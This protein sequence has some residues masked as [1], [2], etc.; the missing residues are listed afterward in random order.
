ML[1]ILTFIVALFC[2]H[3]TY[4]QENLR[5][6][7][8]DEVNKILT[9]AKEKN[10]I[11]YAAASYTKGMQY[12]NEA[13]DYFNRGKSLEDIREKI[14]N[15]QAYLAKSIDVCKI[16]EATFS[17]TT[18]A[19]KDAERAGAPKY[20]IKL[21]NNAEEKFKDAAGKLEEG[22][23]EKSKEKGKEAEST[24]RSAELEAI[25]TNYLSPARELLKN[26]D[27]MEIQDNSPI[28]LSKAKDLVNQTE[29]LLKQNRYDTDEARQL[30][31]EAKYEA[32]HAIYL[33][34]TIEKMKNEEKS[35]EDVLLSSE[36]HLNRVAAELNLSLRF[37][38]G[39]EVPILEII[40]SIKERDAKIIKNADA[41][42]KADE[43]I[44]QKEAE[45]DNLKQQVNLMMAR[46]GSLSEA[47]KKLQNEGKELQRKLELKHEQEATIRRVAAMFTEEE[48][49]VLQ[50]GDN[51][52]I[53]L[54]GLSFPVGKI[55]IEPEYYGLLTKVQGAIREF[56]GSQI[57]I[58]GHTDSQGS[59]DV[60]QTL[61][62][63]RAK[64]V[65]EYLMA[66]MG[67]E[68]PIK[69]QGFG[70]SRPIASNDTQEGRAKNRRID[71][72]ITPEWVKE[73]K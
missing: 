29:N 6:Q 36:F 60:N 51:I 12:Y 42:K 54:Y 45:I 65:A 40:Q 39:F 32:A 44:L 55:T 31:E 37:D 7:L 46:L 49:S 23:T 71:V 28:T 15:A 22:E 13:V 72:V 70:E 2:Y 18:A 61:S 19:R 41:I 69:S 73:A 17:S 53:R 25:K 64:V 59:D 52:I 66:N 20:S 16:G 43:L 50:E 67:V 56:P 26:A 30:A 4:A 14:K 63:R 35:F 8:F 27:D 33:Y 11:F 10:A 62:E 47:E 38:N 21:W 34:Q 48:G 5:S 9:Q 3:L 58:E 68:I 1:L 57:M 24:Y